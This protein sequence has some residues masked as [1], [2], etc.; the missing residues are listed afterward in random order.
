LDSLSEL[1]SDWGFDNKKELYNDIKNLSYA[2]DDSVTQQAEAITKELDFM[3]KYQLLET[4]SFREFHKNKEDV[5]YEF[6]KMGNDLH[7]KKSK[8]WEDK[9][10]IETH[11]RWKLNS[12]D[13]KNLDKLLENE[14]EAK[15]RMLP[16]ETYATWD[17]NNQFKHLQRRSVEEIQ[18]CN[19]IFGDKLQG[20]FNTI[21]QE[22]LKVINRLHVCW[23]DFLGK[24]IESEVSSPLKKSPKKSQKVE[25]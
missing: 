12:N 6:S 17:K 16:K 14:H 7:S 3:L 2:Y 8:L 25:V 19:T 10:K 20:K 24:Y 15:T 9:E 23:G 18:R 11:S 5:Y 22:Q 1:F 4:G 21:A 13:F